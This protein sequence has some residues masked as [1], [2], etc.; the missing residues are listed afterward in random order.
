MWRGRA[1]ARASMSSCPAPS[2]RAGGPYPSRAPTACASA[3]CA[4]PSGAPSPGCGDVGGVVAYSGQGGPGNA[5]RV[6]QSEAARV[7]RPTWRSAVS[8]RRH[9]DQ[10]LGRGVDAGPPDS[11]TVG[12]AGAAMPCRRFANK[13]RPG[14]RRVRRAGSRRFLLP[15]SGKRSAANWTNRQWAQNLVRIECRPASSSPTQCALRWTAMAGRT[16]RCLPPQESDCCLSA[17]PDAGIFTNQGRHGRSTTD[18]RGLAADFHQAYLLAWL[19]LSSVDMTLLKIEPTANNANKGSEQQAR[20]ISPISDPSLG[21]TVRIRLALTSE[22]LKRL[23]R[24]HFDQSR[25]GRQ[26]PVAEE[27]RTNGEP[28]QYAALPS[29]TQTGPR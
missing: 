19:T 8:P 25:R 26:N 1:A 5:W 27:P 23:R 10:V 2:D 7:H 24:L 13:S 3:A 22:Q 11:P 16:D 17:Y 21:C 18:E 12:H 28:S 20:A 6:P 4:S 29:P 14:I 9:L 15:P